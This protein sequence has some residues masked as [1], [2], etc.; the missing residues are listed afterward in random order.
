MKLILTATALVL[1]GSAVTPPPALTPV[2]A[3][4]N[5]TPD[6]IYVPTP[7]EVVEAMLDMAQVK[8]GDVLYDLGSGDG[9]IPIAAAKRAKVR[10]TGIDIDPQRIVEAKANAKAAGVT[11]E[12]TFKQAD[13][14]KSDFSDA[15]VVTLYL[16]DTL[17][18]KLRPKLLAE[19]KPGTRIVSHAFRMGDWVPEQEREVNGRM[20]YFWTVPAKAK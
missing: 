5:R 9:R 13:L 15:T 17:N 8:D 18:E 14:F 10:A 19:L 3:T 1:A 12:V 11:D 7:P 20:V 2:P 16:L 4:Q 6:V